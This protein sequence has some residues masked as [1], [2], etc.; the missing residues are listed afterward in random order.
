MY[1]VPV[2]G[3][4]ATFSDPSESDGDGKGC[5]VQS[6]V[7]SVGLRQVE[8]STVTISPTTVGGGLST[9]DDIGK[10]STSRSGI[11]A[12]SSPAIIADQ[13]VSDLLGVKLHPDSA[14]IISDLL[15]RAVELAG[16]PYKG[17]LSEQL[18]SNV[19]DKLTTTGRIIWC[20]TYK[21][22]CRATFVRRCFFKY[23]GEHMPGFI[24][25]LP[26]IKVLSDSPGGG[27]ETLTGDRLLSFLSR[28]D[29]AI[30]SRAERI[31][32]S[33][34]DEVFCGIS[35]A[36]EGESL[37]AISCEDFTVVLDIAG[38]PLIASSSTSHLKARYSKTKTNSKDVDKCKAS[39]DG[40]SSAPT[41]EGRYASGSGVPAHVSTHSDTGIVCATVGEVSPI[42]YVDLLGFKLHPDSD[43]LISRLFHDVCESA[44]MSYSCS[45]DNYLLTAMNSGL[46]RVG[47]A[48]WCR[49]YRELHLSSFIARCLCI[50][51]YKYRPD[52]IRALPYIRVLS[53]SS[54][55]KPVPL[56]GGSLLV[57]LSKIDCAV[58]VRVKY[59]FKSRWDKVARD[60]FA[61]L[62]D[63]SLSGIRCED[64]INVLDVAGV[65]V[66]ALSDSKRRKVKEKLS[67][68]ALSD[69]KIRIS[70][71]DEGKISESGNKT[72]DK[73][74]TSGGVTADPMSSSSSLQLQSELPSQP[75]PD[76]LPEG[77][78]SSLP[79]VTESIPQ[80][81]VI[82][83]ISKSKTPGSDVV[84]V[85]PGGT[86]SS[87]PPI[88]GSVP[89]IRVIRVISKSKSSGSGDKAAGEGIVSGSG[90]VAVSPD[91][92]GSSS[93]VVAETAPQVRII[94]VI[95][96]SKA[97]GSGINITNAAASG[98][99][100]VVLSPDGTK[101]S[102]PPI[103]GS[104]PQT[105]VIRS[106][107]KNET[108][109]SGSSGKATSDDIVSGS[110]I[111]AASP[112]NAESS[113]PIVTET[114]PQVRVVRVIC[115]RKTLGSGIN[116]T[117]DAVSSGG[118]VVVVS[119]DGTK[120][121]L[122]SITGSVP[123]TRA[124][125]ES[126]ISGSGSE[127]T[128][129]GTTLGGGIVVASPDGAGSSLPPVTETVI[130]RCV[131][132]ESNIS[133]DSSKCAEG[134]ESGS[135]A[136]DL[137]SRLVV[138]LPRLKFQHELSS[139]PE[140]SLSPVD[141]VPQRCVISESKISGD[142]SKCAEGTESGS[143]AIDLT[144]R[145]VVSLPRLKF[146]HELSS[147][148]ESSLSPV[149]TVPRRRLISEGNISGGSSKC[150]EGTE[151]VSST[152]ALTNSPV[153]SSTQLRS[154]LSSQ[155]E[156]QLRS[157]LLLEGK[158]DRLSPRFVKSLSY[159][160]RSANLY[161]IA[162]TSDGPPSNY[163]DFGALV[164][165]LS[166]APSSPPS[167]SFAPLSPSASEPEPQSQY[168]MQL[169][170][171]SGERFSR[172]S[173]DGSVSTLESDA[174]DL[175][176]LEDGS[177]SSE[178][179]SASSSESGSAS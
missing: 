154:E 74:T 17:R 138:S 123:Q 101:S 33:I 35:G 66:V 94:R 147:Q 130:Q 49:M 168:E 59:I 136:I 52:F 133:G 60:V 76:S 137:T 105:R 161:D 30:R 68:E 42:L 92:A 98:G 20:N 144:R 115:K 119:P 140:S 142:S 90:I 11:A 46:S 141:T 58:T 57:F 28:L 64:V 55:C 106:I 9:C 3:S 127:A 175:R 121:S 131:I 157:L 79:I 100:G 69:L 113:L 151:S 162:S 120:S 22:L 41:T 29:S 179:G 72:A 88:A 166:P 36:L 86:V 38:I 117:S 4:A 124:I 143:S 87:L 84:V 26:N 146:Q 89:Q 82:R 85:S 129:E 108:S 132:S 163:S 44:R 169:G 164:G 152:A 148:P 8:A 18:P 165:E 155:S 50:Y 158:Y 145:L 174:S 134:T 103:T 77:T 54:D 70:T 12:V 40:S 97:S 7:S 62:E 24:H 71:T 81:R 128:G 21:V 173:A 16:V 178:S 75:E 23:Y 19:R 135:S 176:V 149:D 99:G 170:S 47:L 93:P 53:S 14:Q 111:V 48:I 80:T 63:G 139:Q 102:L 5:V 37:D 34:W 109:G 114:V 171:L 160:D 31:F 95:S 126:K 1:P 83:V 25:S 61:E 32:I 10:A 122:P 56:S 107:S 156:T 167:I 118:G 112:D 104:V 96:K 153:I 43:E 27:V 15:L 65:P 45:M 39:G 91:N 67:K 110:G 2:T 177:S 159:R 73:G 125:S 78:V 116:V 150:A 13:D 51:H 172:I 6:D